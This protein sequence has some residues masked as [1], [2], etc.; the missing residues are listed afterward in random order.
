[1]QSEG[2]KRHF[3]MY[4]DCEFPNSLEELLEIRRFIT[5]M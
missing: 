5:N 1:M 4:K 2:K 3:Q